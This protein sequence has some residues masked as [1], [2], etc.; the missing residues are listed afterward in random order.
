MSFGVFVGKGK[1]TN[2]EERR[3]RIDKLM[4]K[5]KKKRKGNLL[6]E[7]IHE[8]GESEKEDFKAA[9]LHVD[10]NQR[11][12]NHKSAHKHPIKAGTMPKRQNHERQQVIEEI[13][14]SFFALIHTR[15]ITR[16]SDKPREEQK[17]R[18]SH[19]NSRYDE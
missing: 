12:L 14:P 13:C 15:D 11:D 2:K 5:K 19:E 4:K 3:I 1:R 17:Q 10:V 9:V 16:R 18:E 7:Q 6:E 8:E